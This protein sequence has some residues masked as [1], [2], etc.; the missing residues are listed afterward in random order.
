MRQLRR[1]QLGLRLELRVAEALPPKAARF[2][3]LPLPI[4]LGRIDA[5]D[6]FDAAPGELGE[7]DLAGLAQLLGAGEDFVGEL[8]LSARHANSLTS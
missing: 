4:R 1:G 7:G 5:Q 2:R 8:D 6:V 3:R